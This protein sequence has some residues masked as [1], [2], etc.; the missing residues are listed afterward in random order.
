[1]VTNSVNA[2]ENERLLEGSSHHRHG[3]PVGDDAVR[4]ALLTPV[5]SGALAV[6]GVAGPGA[7]ACVARLFS[8]QG[9]Q[10]LADRPEGAIVFGR[11]RSA[12]DGPGE[13]L[14]VVR[15]GADTLEIHC[16]GGLAASEAVILSLEQLGAM[17]QAWPEWLRAGGTQEIEVEAR[18]ILRAW[19]GSL[20]KVARTR[21]G[22]P[23]TGSAARRVSVCGSCSRGGS[24]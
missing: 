16:H 11:W 12:A 19:R 20:P 6:V 5:G 15:R 13:E 9:P 4:V 23:S 22:L 14:V 1:M 2:W 21:R 18:E 24:S 7:Q 17:R 3:R 10:P 8:P